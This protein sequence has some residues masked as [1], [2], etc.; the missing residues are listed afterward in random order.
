MNV[1]LC[2]TG[3]SEANRLVPHPVQA[4]VWRS[5]VRSPS[6]TVGPRSSAHPKS[7]HP[8]SDSPSHAAERHFTA[9]FAVN[10]VIVVVTTFLLDPDEPVLVED[11]VFFL[12]MV[13]LIATLYDRYRALRLAT[14]PDRT[15]V[16]PSAT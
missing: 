6:A 10:A 4:S 16:A 1:T 9:G 13:T 12:L 11:A 8:K 14:S 15:H 5:S 7:A 3:S 2:S